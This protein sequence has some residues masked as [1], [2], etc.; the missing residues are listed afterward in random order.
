MF[1]IFDKQNSEIEHIKN[2]MAFIEF[3]KDGVIVDA[4]HH[5][6]NLMGYSLSEIK[7]KHHMIFCKES[8]VNSQEYVNF[9]ATLKMGTYIKGTFTRIKKSGEVVYLEASYIPILENGKVNKFIKIAHDITEKEVNNLKLEAELKAL[10]KSMARIEFDANGKVMNANQTFLNVLGYSNIEEIK[11]KEHKIFCF[12]EFLKSGEYNQFWNHLRAGMFHQ[13]TY[14]RKKKNGDV[15]WIEAAYSPVLNDEKKVIGVVKLALDVTKREIRNREIN[16]VLS[17]IRDL[18]EITNTKSIAMKENS[19]VGEKTLQKLL[20]NIQGGTEKVNELNNISNKIS[21]ITDGITEISLK[22]NILALNAAIEA[23][24]AGESGKGF[25]VVAGEVRNLAN[26]TQEKA[27]EINEFILNMKN[28]T[29]S[30]VSSLKEFNTETQQVVSEY[31]KTISILDELY[32]YNQNI[33]NIMLEFESKN[34]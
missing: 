23:A 8:L 11:G 19:I 28:N 22:T 30:T 12:D 14:K 26:L 17:E 1:N 32:N 4:N 25:A 5:F 2:C 24:R 31:E 20:S 27:K 3:N 29:N 6:L 16:D 13:D 7:G 18:I 33:S 15:V 34:R 10:D 21:G 9:W